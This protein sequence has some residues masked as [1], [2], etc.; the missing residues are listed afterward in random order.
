MRLRILL[1]Y[2]TLG[3]LNSLA[4]EPS[5]NEWRISPSLKYDAFYFINAISKQDFYNRM[6]PRDALLWRGRLG[7]Q[8]INSINTIIDSIGSVGFKASYL[9]TH[10]PVFSL[11][12]LIHA[13][14][15]TAILRDRIQSASLLSKD[16]RY[17]A[18]INDLNRI[19][20]HSAR[21]ITI[22]SKMRDERWEDDWK[23]IT[24]RL[25]ADIARK[26]RELTKHSPAS[27]RTEA[28]RFLGIDARQKDSSSTVY[29]VY[30]AFPNAFKL[31][32]NMM[33]TWSIE[34]PQYFF[35]AYLHEMLHLFSI[36]APEFIELHNHLLKHSPAFS[37][38]RN[39][40]VKQLYASDDEFYVLAAE[41]FLSI[42][43][44]IRTHQ[45]AVDYLK[46]ANGGTVVYSL[47]IYDHLQKSFDYRR[48]SFGSFLKDVFFKNV[49]ATEVEAFIADTK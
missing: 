30:Y 2:L 7:E 17:E 44:G 20:P 25:N 26:R 39:I 41:A 23:A 8:T 42:K 32:Y 45:Q 36:Y 9:F 16:F 37:Q 40:L 11:D 10:I 22:F 18:S 48:H 49:T 33:A 28:L 27:L 34:E 14:R 4:Q 29:Y 19:L 24:H 13:L 43:V 6:Y 12:D 35:S 46:S 47:L 21:L 5:T 31:P 3:T 38:Q 15:D 1:I